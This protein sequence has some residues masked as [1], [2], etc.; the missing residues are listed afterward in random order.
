MKIKIREKGQVTGTLL[1][2][3][4]KGVQ[5]IVGKFADLIYEFDFYKFGTF[6]SLYKMYIDREV[7]YERYVLEIKSTILT[8]KIYKWKLE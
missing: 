6:S 3:N 1:S 4:T 5:L 8:D 7:S 2:K